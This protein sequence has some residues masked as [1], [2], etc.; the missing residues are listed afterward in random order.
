MN[1]ELETTNG[2]FDHGF[3]PHGG[4]YDKMFKK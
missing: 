1:F 3:H 4:E 2:A